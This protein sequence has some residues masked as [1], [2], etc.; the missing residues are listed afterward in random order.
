[1]PSIRWGAATGADVCLPFN[2]NVSLSGC[3]LLGVPAADDGVALA[4]NAFTSDANTVGLWHMDEAS[5]VGADSVLDASASAAH[6]T[7]YNSATTALGAIDRYGD[8]YGSKYVLTLAVAWGNASTTL[9][10]WVL[11]NSATAVGGTVFQSGNNANWGVRKIG[12]GVYRCATRA[13]TFLNFNVAENVWQHWCFQ[14]SGKGSA[15]GVQTVHINGVLVATGTP[16]NGNCTTATCSMGAF[17]TGIEPSECYMDE[18]RASNIARY[19]QVGNFTAPVWRKSAAQNSG[20]QPYVQVTGTGLAGMLPTAVSWTA[21]TGSA[22]G[23][24]HSVWVQDAALGWTQVGGS[25]PTSPVSVSGLTLASNDAVRI[26]LEPE[27][28]SGIQNA[29]PLLDWLQLDY[30]VPVSYI[31]RRIMPV[32]LGPRLLP[33]G[34]IC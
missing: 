23:R 34:V 18:V 19:S 8:V 4:F 1:M 16:G 32:R 22:Y 6:G 25:Y 24:I 30:T 27:A 12:A 20:V 15:G 26:A 9:E 21:Q 14:Q 5:W 28:V 31:P 33:I 3:Q 10:F 13:G 17:T 29:S 11:P 7:P 2:G